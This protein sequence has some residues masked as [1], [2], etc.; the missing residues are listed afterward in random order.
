MDLKE[1][2]YVVALARHG[3]IT[4]AAEELFIT[5]PTLSIFISRLETRMGIRLFDRVGKKF[6]PTYAG[7]IYLKRARELLVI[8]KEFED[9][10]SDLISGCTG[11][12]RLGI[13]SRRSTY[14]L[15]GVLKEFHDRYPQIEVI[16]TETGSKDMEEKLLAGELDLIIT[17]RFFNK[18]SLDIIPVYDDR[19]ILSIAQDHPAC[20][21]AI[22]IP[23]HSYL[24]LD[25][26]HVLDERFILQTPAQ[27]IRTFTDAALSY[28]GVVPRRTF[29][30]ENMETA[31]Q[32]AAEGYGVA[33]NYESY[34][35]YFHYHKP[36]ACFLVGFADFCFPISIACRKG[37]YLPAHVSEFA[38]LVKKQFNGEFP[39]K[40]TAR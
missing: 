8:Q 2:E 39:N 10:L 36:I 22:A 5:Q 28:A 23:G 19:L 31:S 13:H 25:L 7:E 38:E 17:N 33:F 20:K 12:L 16:L 29:V 18:D 27:S 3:S 40:E 26:K 35:K 34:I 24:W 14:L 9:E 6:I 11:R 1:Q 30:I 15:P 4:K 32:M 37:A 21:R